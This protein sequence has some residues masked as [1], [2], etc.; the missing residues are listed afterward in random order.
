MTRMRPG[1]TTSASACA[2]GTWTCSGPSAAGPRWQRSSRLDEEAHLHVVREHVE[3]GRRARALRH[4]ETM[5]RLWRDE[6]GLG[7]GTDALALRARAESMPTIDPAR[8]VPNRAAMPVPRPPTRTVGRS[9]DVA[10]VLSLLED[11]RLVTLLGIGGVG[12]TRLAAEVAHEF[13]RTTELRTCYVDLTKVADPSQV[14]EL[15]VRELGIRAGD[16]QPVMQVLRE[17]LLRQSLLIV[18]DNYEHV[19]DAADVVPR[20]LQMS[21]DLRVL[22]TSRARLRVAGEQVFEVRP[23][24]VGE[25]EA[26]GPF[27]DAVALFDQVARSVDPDFDL[28]QH[29]DDVT[30]ICR[31]V[32]GLPLA[33]EIAGG[34]LR[35]LSPSLLRERL[36]GRLASGSAAARDLP[37]R[38]Q[39]IP[40]AIDWSLQLLGPEERRLFAL[41]SVFQ[42]SVTLDAVEAVWTEGDVVDPLGI[43][44]DHSLVR[45]TAGVRGEPRF[46]MLAL[47]RDHAATLLDAE[48]ERVGAA[49]AS[50]VAARL[51][52]LYERRWT[53]AAD[54]WLDEIGELF[55][56]VRDGPRVGG[57][58]RDWTLAARITAAL[59]AYWFLEGHH[60]EG[61]RWVEEA[62]ARESELDRADVGPPPPGCGLPGV[63]ARAS[64]THDST[65]S[66]P[67]SC[68]ASS[69]RSGCWPTRWRSRPRRT[70]AWRSTTGSRCS[71]TTRRCSSPAGTV[72]RRSWPRPSTSAASSPGWRATT[73]WRGRRT[74]R[75][76]RSRATSTTRCTSA[77]SSPTSATSPTTGVT[78]PRP[79]G[80]PTRRSRSAGRSVGG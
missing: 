9:H 78:T 64:P 31:S 20:L 16:D 62:L 50:Y 69:G 67:S 17:A 10:S 41:L 76:C 22:V 56:E 46:G 19:A 42:G 6:L 44:V 34:H 33:I 36:A 53:D 71:S 25:S 18:M 51:G 73:T 49:H 40:A 27:G 66:A 75:D 68:S 60:G 26:A 12:K 79:A 77:S 30:E 5:E 63:P 52:D 80:S 55:R 13:A 3:G 24:P 74:R 1:P 48:R 14:A 61:Q 2:C 70:S 43:L 28:G 57:S 72:A 15:V 39:T 29:L 54:R 58:R 7:P 4:L 35:T 65:G 8:L 37:D 38:Q 21:G 45:R 11:S 32:D 47:V 59:G 23:L